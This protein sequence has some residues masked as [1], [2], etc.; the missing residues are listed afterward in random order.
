M[1]SPMAA[2]RPSNVELLRS[3]LRHRDDPQ[4]FLDAMADRAIADLGIDVDGDRVLDLGCGSGS[5]AVRLRGRGAEIVGI[6][7]SSEDLVEG[8][9][10]LPTLVRADGG[11]LPFPDGTFDGVYCSNVLEHTPDPGAIFNEIA[12]VVRPG[13]WSWVS[14]TNWYSPVGGHDIMVLNYLGPT[15]G[16]ALWTRLRGRPERNVPFDGLWPTYVGKMLALA[17]STEGLRL[18]DAKPRYYPSQRWLLRVPGLREVATWNCVLLF[19]RAGSGRV[20]S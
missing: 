15:L 19:E 5:D 14:W 17:R 11:R 6:D 1:T 7:L 4:P 3:Y 12:R 16:P 18:V 8:R 2:H 20:T 9:S 13:G 10:E